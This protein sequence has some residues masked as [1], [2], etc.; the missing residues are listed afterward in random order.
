MAHIGYHLLKT[1]I[2]QTHAVDNSLIV[3]KFEDSRLRISLLR[4]RGDSTKLYKAEAQRIELTEY[5][6]IAIKARRH[7]YRIAKMDAEHIALER[8]MLNGIE[9]THKPPCTWNFTQYA[10]HMHSAEMHPFDT[11]KWR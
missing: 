8:G 6:A 5:I 10:K 3:R 4:L 9:F 1:I 2:T 11:D 7:T